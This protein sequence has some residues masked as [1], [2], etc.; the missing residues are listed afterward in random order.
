MRTRGARGHL[1]T[2]SPQ[3]VPGL[4]CARSPSESWAP[5]ST[6]GEPVETS[7]SAGRSGY[8]LSSL[9][10]TGVLK[11]HSCARSSPGRL[12]GPRVLPRSSAALPELKAHTSR[13]QGTVWI[14]SRR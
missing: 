2:S 5:L 13:Q 14:F 8:L 11:P 9:F 4:G 10:I 12:W 6:G 1:Q 3:A 7:S